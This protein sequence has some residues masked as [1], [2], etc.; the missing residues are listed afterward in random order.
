[1]KNNLADFLKYELKFLEKLNN[2]ISNQNSE[3]PKI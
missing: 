1:M 2:L 3:L